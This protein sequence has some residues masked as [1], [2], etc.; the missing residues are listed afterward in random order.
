MHTIFGGQALIKSRVG[1]LRLATDIASRKM[2]EGEKEERA[3]SD[4]S[5]N[6]ISTPLVAFIFAS[7][8]LC[9]S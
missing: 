4:S 9:Q 6:I 2:K 1:R 3:P 7:T 8:L 5:F